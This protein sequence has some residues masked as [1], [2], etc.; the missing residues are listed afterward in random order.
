[1]IYMMNDEY[2]SYK[3]VA[4]CLKDIIEIGK[5]DLTNPKYDDYFIEAKEAIKKLEK[6][7]K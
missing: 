4:Q 7:L 6:E 1:M 3:E 2:N 5:R